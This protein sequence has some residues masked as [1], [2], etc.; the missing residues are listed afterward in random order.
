MNA[1]LTS[2][3]VIDLSASKLLPLHANRTIVLHRAVGIRSTGM[4][5][6]LVALA[7]GHT[8]K[9]E[10]HH[11]LE[12]EF[13][14]RMRL[15]AK[16]AL[17]PLSLANYGQGLALVFPDPGGLPLCNLPKGRLDIG[18]FL[19]I[20]LALTA[21]VDEMHASGMLHLALHSSGILLANNRRV[22]LTGFGKANYLSKAPAGFECAT[23]VRPIRPKPDQ[24]IVLRAMDGHG[25]DLHALGAILYELLNG[26]PPFAQAD[27]IDRQHSLSRTG[28]S[29]QLYERLS[30]ILM[31]FLDRSSDQCY[32][33]AKSALA[34]L[35]SCRSEWRTV[36]RI[37]SYPSLPRANSHGLSAAQTALARE[38]ANL[39]RQLQLEKELRRNA[40]D[41]LEASKASIGIARL[42]TRTGTWR[43]NIASGEFSCC[44]EFMRLLGFDPAPRTA[45]IEEFM[46]QVHCDDRT[47]VE[48][49]LYDA[50]TM[51]LCLQH[52]FRITLPDGCLRHLR[53]VGQVKINRA[54]RL[55]F[56]GSAM[57][58]GHEKRS[59]EALRQVRGELAR[60]ARI[61]AMGKMAASMAHDVSQPLAAIV[62]NADAGL[63]WLRQQ[64]AQLAQLE[65][66][67]KQIRQAG[68]SA[69]SMIRSIRGMACK[70]GPEFAPF[71]VDDAIREVLLLFR[72]ELQNR[73]I[74]VFPQLTLGAHLLNADRAQLQQVM[75]NLLL[76]AIDAMSSIKNRT[77]LLHVRSTIIDKSGTV[78]LSIEDNGTGIDAKSADRLFD[79]LFSTKPDG[80]GMGLA[81]CRS[82]VEAH[83]GRIWCTSRQPDGT[84]FHVSFPSDSARVDT[85]GKYH[86][87]NSEKKAT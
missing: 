31:K 59:D 68:Q 18:D 13:D 57:D 10:A 70:S 53:S 32:Q 4:D 67:L 51:Q 5:T 1:I 44:E 22:Y 65:D 21:A 37:S 20:A 27:C 45:T 30:L 7:T 78:R 38:N 56:C 19:S 71:V 36:S 46:A 54:G 62:L 6:V 85:P 29:P 80:M 14:L 66:A 72:A 49:E 86:I 16:W 69:G 2:Q 48:R 12:R 34:D 55:E 9:Q 63:C 23:N 76:N 79:P 77:R 8:R 25:D 3:P 60:V 15:D 26:E 11:L 52:E 24:R 74:S 58:V 73:K 84:S 75:M 40:E 33:S 17:P 83:N 50:I 41:A 42:L 28:S 81:I 61:S 87:F 39:S 35:I 82:I 43:W 47:R 64:P